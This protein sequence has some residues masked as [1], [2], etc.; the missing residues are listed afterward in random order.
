MKTPEKAAFP[1]IAFKIAAWYWL[2]NAYV[3]KSNETS[4]KGSLNQLADGTY[5]SFSLLA[6]SLINDLSD[7]LKR[8]E[9]NDNILK[10]LNGRPLKKGRGVNCVL[11]N[12][13]GYTVPI[14]L[15]NQKSEYC[16]CEGEF[17]KEKFCE[18]GIFNE[19][20]K[21]KNPKFIR[22]CVENFSNGI[23][24]VNFIL[25]KILSKT[26]FLYFRQF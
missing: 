21:C 18:Y 5:H 22:C 9:I 1:S 19:H 15:S 2:N 12:Q 8:L 3:T 16:G 11:N 4:I 20:K 7:L 25:I 6:Y 14:C 17:E 23:D 26:Y 13:I 10:E 24:L